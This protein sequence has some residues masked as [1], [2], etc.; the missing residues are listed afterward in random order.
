MDLLKSVLTSALVPAAQDQV[1]L[2]GNSSRPQGVPVLQA[3]DDWQHPPRCIPILH[4]I[5]F[6]EE[7][8]KDDVKRRTYVC[9]A[10]HHLLGSRG[11]DK[12][13]NK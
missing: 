8:G 1:S 10:L 9:G 5:L 12:D 6:W 7:Q 3:G 4:F 2:L 13:K 11:K